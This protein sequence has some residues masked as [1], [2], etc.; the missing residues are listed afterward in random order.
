MTWQRKNPI[1]QDGVD[2]QSRTSSSPTATLYRFKP[3][4]SRPNK[5]V[6]TKRL[7]RS[8]DTVEFYSGETGFLVRN[9]DGWQSA[10]CPFHD[11]THP[12]L[13]VL[14]PEGAFCCQACGAKGGDV[15]AFT[16]QKYHKN[17]LEA[18]CFL[19]QEYG[20]VA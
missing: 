18:V 5:R 15:I 7:K 12:S 16:M 11:D 20:G 10:L 8:I 6:D 19:K 9:E 4:S 17:F 1:G 13:S 14:I 3:P 2:S